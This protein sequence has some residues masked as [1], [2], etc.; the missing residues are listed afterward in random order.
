MKSTNLTDTYIRAARRKRGYL[1]LSLAALLL[2][3]VWA[4]CLG[5]AEL[6]PGRILSTWIPEAGS[7]LKAEPLNT[8]EIN[9][10][11]MLRLPRVA[12]AVAAGAGLGAAGASM[13]AITGNSMASPFTTGLS[14][15]AALG[16]AAVIVFGGFPVYMQK[17]A[18]VAAAFCMAALC[19][20]LVFGI[21]NYKGM[22]AEALVLTGIALNYLFSALNSTMQFIANEQQ[23]PAIVHWSFGSLN[24]VGWGDI[25]IMTGCFLLAFP[26]LLSQA[27]AFNLLDSGGDE[28]ARALGIHTRKTRLL[29]GGAITL[30]TAAVVSFTGIIGFVGLV[31]P[32]IARLLLGGDYKQ[33][34]PFSAVSGAA[35]VLAADTLGRNAFSPTTIP[36]GIVVSYVGVPLFLGL[37][38]RGRRERL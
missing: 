30:M 10:L 13:Q 34:L 4:C 8:K 35:L 12:A 20:V 18:T 24:S 16:A 21:A 17:T 25:G 32:H 9:I 22:G 6:T 7:F 27:R 19:A 37:I 14:G 3:A 38:L 2:M 33:I 29:T 15:A 1:V 5:V 28:T 11:L 26:F 23:L 31:A 36:V